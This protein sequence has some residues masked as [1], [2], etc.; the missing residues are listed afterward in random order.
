MGTPRLS[1][2]SLPTLSSQPSLSLSCSPSR[3]GDCYI[4]IWVSGSASGFQF[5]VFS[6][7]TH[8]DRCTS[9]KKQQIKFEKILHK[10]SEIVQLTVATFLFKQQRKKKQKNGMEVKWKSYGVCNDAF[11][12]FL[13]SIW[14]YCHCFRCA[15]IVG[16]ASAPPTTTNNRD[17]PSPA[18]TRKCL[19]CVWQQSC[20][21]NNLPNKKIEARNEVNAFPIADNKSEVSS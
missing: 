20:L 7:Q 1:P 10:Y 6:F 13:N 21:R 12:L 3:S 15:P 19:Q 17:C 4:L 8:V 11:K 2:R 14:V 16:V 18:G 9:L 5:L